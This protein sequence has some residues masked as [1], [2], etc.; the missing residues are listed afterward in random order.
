MGGA[1]TE[2][3]A[4]AVRANIQ[5][6]TNARSPPGPSNS[7]RGTGGAGKEGGS[8]ALALRGV[9]GGLK[10]Q[11]CIYPTTEFSND[12]ISFRPTKHAI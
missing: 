1:G 9:S 7:G 12:Q 6:V 2:W 11:L 8:A 5:L 10:R 3:G 4:Q